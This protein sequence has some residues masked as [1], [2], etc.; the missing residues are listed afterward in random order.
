MRA[1]YPSESFLALTREAFSKRE[2]HV[3]LITSPWRSR[4]V[5]REIH[6]WAKSLAHANEI[7]KGKSKGFPLCM[8]LMPSL[9]SMHHF[10]IAHGY[11]MSFDLMKEEVEIRYEYRGE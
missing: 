9:M 3:M 4:L 10:A 2:A 6:G 11:V 8:F 7:A 1:T 5:A